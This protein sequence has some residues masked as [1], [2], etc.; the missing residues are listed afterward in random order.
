MNLKK[1][2]RAKLV[3]PTAYVDVPELADW[4][5]DEGEE[6][7]LKVRGL[8]AN[9]QFHIR[10]QQLKRHPMLQLSEKLRAAP[11]AE[12]CVVAE[13]VLKAAFGA[14][15]EAV[16]TSTAYSIELLVYG[17]IDEQGNRLFDYQDAVKISEHFPNVF[18]R[19]SNKI[20]ELMGAAS[21]LQED[22]RL[23]ESPPSFGPTPTSKTPSPSLNDSGNA[24]TSAAR[25]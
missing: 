8:T 9:E 14:D 6:P 18:I 23:G 19:L 2:R 17:V 12:G 21:V 22:R 25:T 16:T 7:R 3:R 5:F 4:L 1:L 15:K 24:S 20:N 13:D 10:E 11:E